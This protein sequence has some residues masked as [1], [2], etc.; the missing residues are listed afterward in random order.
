MA[1]LELINV[2]LQGFVWFGV[3]GLPPTAPNLFG[4]SLVALLLLEGAGY[5]FAKHDQVRR[6]RRRL[7]AIAAFRV[8]R[9]ANLV[10]LGSGL[11]ITATAVLVAPGLATWPGLGFVL[12][13]MLEHLNYFHV[14]LMHDTAADLHRLRSRGLRRS[15]LARDLRPVR[16][17]RSAHAENGLS[18]V[19]RG[20]RPHH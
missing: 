13:A 8:A 16:V 4:F 20:S 12:F 3:L 14:Q 15:H 5:W 6:G 10:F 18:E 1:A 2:P 9:L 17:L 19:P 7:P 11:A